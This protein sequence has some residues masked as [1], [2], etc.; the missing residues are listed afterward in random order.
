MIAKD[1]G[2]A[3]NPKIIKQFEVYTWHSYETYKQN[4]DTV[5]VSFLF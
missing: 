4:S 5:G 1:K 3:E 2:Q